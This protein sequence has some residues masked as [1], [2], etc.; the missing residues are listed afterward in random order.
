MHWVVMIIEIQKNSTI[1][2]KI[3]KIMKKKHLVSSIHKELSLFHEFYNREKFHDPGASI[4]SSPMNFQGLH[5]FFP[6]ISS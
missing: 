3:T 6:Q 2:S 1:S 4:V 5:A